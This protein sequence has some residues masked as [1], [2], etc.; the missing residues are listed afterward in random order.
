MEGIGELI[1]GRFL[2]SQLVNFLILFVALYFL[3]W[4]RALKMF[5]ERKQKIAQGL[6]D[7]EGARAKLADAET[8]RARI[9]EEAQRERDQIIAQAKQEAVE[10]QQVLAAEAQAE[11]SRILQ[12]AEGSLDGEREEMLSGLRGQVATLAI[13]AANKIVGEALDDG[14]QRQL[15]DEFFSGV[16]SGRV[17][18]LDESGMDLSASGASGAVSVTSALPLSDEEK[19]TVGRSLAERMGSE[20]SLEFGVDPAIMGGVRIRVGDRVIDGSVAGKLDA[21]RESLNT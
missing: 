4:K 8:E 5:D 16:A 11:R 18:V 12:D 13:A 3:L 20:P 10:A 14:R 9:V 7:A 2:L 19:A 15:V 6:E 17:S 1:N 21:L